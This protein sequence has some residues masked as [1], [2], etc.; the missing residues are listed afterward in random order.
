MLCRTGMIGM[1]HIPDRFRPDEGGAS[2]VDTAS[3]PELEGRFILEALKRNEWNREQTARELGMH[4]T[5]LWRKVKRLGLELP[6][7]DGRNRRTT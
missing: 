1:R 4:K 5:T 7:K 6:S 3:L 2:P